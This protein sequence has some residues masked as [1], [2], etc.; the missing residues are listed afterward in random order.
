MSTSRYTGKERDAESGLDYFGARY[1]GSSMGRFMSP[2]WSEDPLPIPYVDVANPQ[3][4]NL[5]SYVANNPLS[6][7]D[8]DG[9]IML[10]PDCPCNQPPIQYDLLWHDF[11][12]RSLR[13]NAAVS[14]YWNQYFGKSKPV[15]PA[16]VTPPQTANPNPDDKDKPK[17]T[18]NPKHHP[19]SNS[20]EP[21]NVQ[22]LFDKSIKDDGTGARWA[23]DGDGTIH[24]FSP[25]SN[26]E[27]HWNGSTGGE[28]PIRMESI[29]NAIRTALK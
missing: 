26:G 2:D 19:N 16:S 4:L 7:T 14:S 5:Y 8:P 6:R 10:N 21:A 18:H 29:P 15:A 25:E 27:T 23:K 28:N 11:I 22:E 9:H 13:F 1:Y 24:R 12:Q 17:L 20:P 3:S